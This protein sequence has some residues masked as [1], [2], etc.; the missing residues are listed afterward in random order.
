MKFEKR[1]DPSN[2][3]NS[4]ESS[5]PAEPK[6]ETSPRSKPVIIYIMILFIAAFLLMAL[7]FFMHQRSNTEVLGQLHDSVTVMQE[8]QGYQD[9]IIEL[10]E[11]L[12]TQN[13]LLDQEKAAAEEQSAVLEA[14]TDL[15]LLQQAYSNQD[16]AACQRL[17]DH[18]EESG[19]AKKLPT[20]VDDDSSV[21]APA[22]R[23]AQFKDAVSAILALG[24]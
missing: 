18:M 13:D 15:Y 19:S 16:Y 9:K 22:T 20:Q 17:I 7:S 2:S 21:T 10:Q 3:S 1:T 24:N 11:E 6:K 23:Y 12:D 4:P 14:M 8:V 5:Q